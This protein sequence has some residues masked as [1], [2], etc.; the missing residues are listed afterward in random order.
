MLNMKSKSN[1]QMVVEDLADYE[2]VDTSTIVGD[3][4]HTISEALIF[5]LNP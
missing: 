1:I 3:H 5:I 4:I 2:N